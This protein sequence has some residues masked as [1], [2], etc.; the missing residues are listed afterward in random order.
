MSQFI[1]KKKKKKE[2]KIEA[3]FFFKLNQSFSILLCTISQRFKC[4][5]ISLPKTISSI[6]VFDVTN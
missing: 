6:N 1:I 4:W 2:T 3:G 5:I